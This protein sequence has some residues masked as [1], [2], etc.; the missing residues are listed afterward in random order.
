MRAIRDLLAEQADLAGLPDSDLELMAGCGVNIVCSPGET[1]AREGDPAETFLVI[2]AGRVALDVEAPG[3]GALRM[4]TLGPG[5]LVGWSW[6]VP[7]YRWSA[8]VVAVDEVH[9]VQIDAACLRRKCDEDTALG[10]RLMQR[11]AHLTA[12]RLQ[13]TRLQ[14]LDLYAANSDGA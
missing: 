9:A 1:L 11:V 5:E 2:R 3:R 4:L 8:D 7:P 6:L 10:Y 14:L 13:T 12:Q